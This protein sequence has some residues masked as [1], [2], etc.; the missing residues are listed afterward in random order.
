L[1]PYLNAANSAAGGIAGAYEN[2]ANQVNSNQQNLIQDVYGGHVGIG[3][4]NA[5]VALSNQSL[6]LGLLGGGIS[7]L[8]G[9][10]GG[11]LLGGLGTLGAGLT[12][13]GIGTFGGNFG[14]APNFS[15]LTGS[16]ERL[17]EHIEPVG[18]LYDGQQIYRYNYIGDIN[19]R[20]GLMAQE[21][22]ED[23]PDAIGDRFWLSR[24]RLRPG[25]GSRSRTRPVLGRGRLR[26]HFQSR[27]GVG[28]VPGSGVMRLSRLSLGY[29]PGIALPREIEAER[30]AVPSAGCAGS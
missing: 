23:N 15:L 17:K 8:T 12:G 5:S 14:S 22:A 7:A 2:N 24:R 28:A 1:Q 18:E 25:H 29:A 9:G 11:G 4:A 26:S 10:L 21:V 20:I 16:D 19:P 6:G 3:N 27:G 13:G 30:V